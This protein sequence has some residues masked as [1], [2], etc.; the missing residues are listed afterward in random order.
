MVSIVDTMQVNYIG[1]STDTKPGSAANGSS[2]YEMDSGT[3]YYYDEDGRQ[4]VTATASTE[5]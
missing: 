1:L 5:P 2:F 3:T 4:W